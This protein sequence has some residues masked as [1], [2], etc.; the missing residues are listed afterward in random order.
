MPVL[1]IAH[2]YANYFKTLIYADGHYG[3][4]GGSG[5]RSLNCFKIFWFII[6]VTFLN[7]YMCI[8]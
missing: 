2:I 1:L 4:D 7:W 5:V 8:F 6:T 3:A